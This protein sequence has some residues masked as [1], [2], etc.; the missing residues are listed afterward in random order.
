MSALPATPPPQ[1]PNSPGSSSQDRT[2]T[3][4]RPVLASGEHTSTRTVMAPGFST[5][6]EVGNV[7]GLRLDQILLGAASLLVLVIIA[8]L[9]VVQ[10]VTTARQ[11]DEIS[12]GYSERIQNR[13]RELGLTLSHTLSL[14][15]AS[16]L[17]DSNYAFLSEVAREII[18]KNPNVLRVQVADPEGLV[19]ADSDAAAEAGAQLDRAMER[20]SRVGTFEGKPVYEYQEPIDYG[21]SAGKGLVVLYY[22]LEA[23]Q[24]EL[25]ELEVAKG[26]A[27]REVV[28][29][30]AALGGGFL[31]LAGVL[32]AVFSRRI[33]R[34]L[35]ALTAG[36]KEL[37]QGNLETRVAPGPS[38]REVGTLGAVF[39]HMAERMSFLMEDARVKAAL[40]RDMMLARQVQEA[41]L[42]GR[43]PLRAGPLQ[44]AG[45]VVAADATGGD[46]W[47]R[48]EL[49][50]H[51][52]VLG[53]GDATGHGL[54]AALVACSASAGFAAALRTRSVSETTAAGLITSLNQTLHLIGR[55]EQQM[56]S[57]LAVFDLQ[58]GEVEYASGGHPSALVVN[59]HT[60]DV[61]SLLS[62][63]SL[64]GASA[65]SQYASRTA[66]LKNGDILVWYTDGLTESENTSRQQYGTQRLLACV[67]QNLT[68]SA[69]RLRDAI[70]F[71]V[72]QHSGTQPQNDDITVVV[73]EYSPH[74]TQ[75]AP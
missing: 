50:E 21:S 42:P 25:R 7:Q 20:A 45:V 32:A 4:T 40:E 72:R 66:Q 5:A 44:I 55:G 64:L 51:K 11:F 15:S 65:Q 53:V 52:V 17:R 59:R 49:D 71:D 54:A 23:L 47:L 18:E 22:S 13:A 6:L 68:L 63:G 41:L 75:A 9:G 2:G 14:T 39:N 61:G 69:E 26:G 31:L 48:A 30:T 38:S 24:S 36:A 27:V 56:S 57:A 35:N 33:T 37:A 62:R 19:V 74:P 58:K 73:A 1:S 60:G 3:A 46:W 8:L 16:A 29:R 10:A 43:E 28:I 67:R 34:P 70:L 12:A